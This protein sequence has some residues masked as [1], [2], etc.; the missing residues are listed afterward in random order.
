MSSHIVIIIAEIRL[1]LLAGP[2]HLKCP[3]GLLTMPTYKFKDNNSGEEFEKWMYMADREKYLADNPNVTQ[4]PTLLH[5]V[6]EV[7]NWQNKTD[8]DWKTIVNRAAN[9]IGRAS[10]RERV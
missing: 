1:L 5:A 6:S 4:M 7:G 2:P 9:E 3:L 10:C 8:S